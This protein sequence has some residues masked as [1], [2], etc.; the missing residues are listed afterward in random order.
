MFEQKFLVQNM[1]CITVI[2]S[3][4][5]NLK[6][7]YCLLNKSVNEK[8][9][10]MQINTMK[11]LEDGSFLEN[12]K[13]SMIKLEIPFSQI[14]RLELWGQEPTLT[15]H[16]W[17]KHIE[18]WIDTFPNWRY[19]MFSTN[20]ME[21]PERIVELIKRID[22]Y[23]NNTV[24]LDLQISYDG[25]ES[26]NELRG[27]ND[28]KIFDNISY[29][30]NE[31]NFIKLNHVDVNMYLHGV[32]SVALLRKLDSPDKILDYY[33]IMGKY[34]DDLFKQIINPAIKFRRAPDINLET[35]V[36]ASTEEGLL[37]GNFVRNSLSLPESAFY[38]YH[39][40]LIRKALFI[41]PTGI[42]D[43]VTPFGVKSY[44][45]FI[46]RVL[47]NECDFVKMIDDL[48][49]FPYCG[50]N[51]GSLHFKYDGTITTCQSMIF[52]NEYDYVKGQNDFELTVKKSLIEKKFF[53]N[54]LTASM[55]ECQKFL[56]RFSALKFSTY[57]FLLE[58]IMNMMF[59]MSK[60]H[61][62]DSRYA[63]DPILLFK[64][65][66]IITTYNCCVYNNRIK[67]GSMFVRWDG[68]VRFM[69]NG[70]VDEVEA[71]IDNL[72]KIQEEGD[73][74]AYRLL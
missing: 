58:Q 51:S 13:N 15:L 67:T 74:D 23:T 49:G 39:A 73:K 54:P 63:H 55:E 9:P 42:L 29:I 31:L 26:T 25:E 38:N 53:L 56:Y 66:L 1:C 45:E 36:Q 34:G 41:Q 40:S 19:L 59:W 70:F 61:Q 64:H 21:Y 52:D 46:E 30:I 35:P 24:K 57:P 69:C 68:Y 4:G 48:Q 43:I 72:L 17:T 44:N 14:T 22:A 8:S 10:E 32:L 18:D 7:E 6:C 37:L 47:S 11:A 65:A 28:Q 71:E 33:N 12:I 50:T 60:A 16:L 5:C 2:S 3:C 20:G 27:A 62:I